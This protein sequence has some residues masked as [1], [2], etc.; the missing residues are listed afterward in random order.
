MKEEYVDSFPSII[1]PRRSNCF[2]DILP[3]SRLER[4]LLIKLLNFS[5]SSGRTVSISFNGIVF[6]NSLY[7]QHAVECALKLSHFS[8]PD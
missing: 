7:G 3:N 4:L 6:I 1:S 8:H 5:L 2:S